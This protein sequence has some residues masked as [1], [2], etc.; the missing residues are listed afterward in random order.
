MT[1]ARVEFLLTEGAPASAVASLF[2]GVV[3][4]FTHEINNALTGALTCVQTLAVDPKFHATDPTVIHDIETSLFR[5]VDI[6]RRLSAMPWSG[7]GSDLSERQPITELLSAAV[8]DFH[9]TVPA[10]P[11]PRLLSVATEIPNSARNFAA[12]PQQ[13]RQLVCLLL[14]HAAR[15]FPQA[16][17]IRLSVAADSSGLRIAVE[18]TT[19]SSVATTVEPFTLLLA[20]TLAALQGYKLNKSDMEGQ[21]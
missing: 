3:R 16:E 1:K 14:S 12:N 2:E 18:P 11:Q 9:Q 17:G 6:S 4:C 15:K 7:T 5:C 8:D 19:P 10:M 13:F 20:E 21:R